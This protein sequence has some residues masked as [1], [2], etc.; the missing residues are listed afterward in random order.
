MICDKE[1]PV[2]TDTL[3]KHAF[4]FRAV[5]SFHIA[6]EGVGFH[7]REGPRDAPEYL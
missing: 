7:L 3:A 4:P 1:E 6:L 5:Q 2:I